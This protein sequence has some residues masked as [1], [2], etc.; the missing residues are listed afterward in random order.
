MECAGKCILKGLFRGVQE[1]EKRQS[2][3]YVRRQ[4]SQKTILNLS[5]LLVYLYT[6]FCAYAKLISIG[7]VV[8]YAASM[9]QMMDCANKMAVA[10]GH[11]KSAAMY[12]ADYRKFLTLQDR[13]Y[14][15]TII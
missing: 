5:T 7:Q 12:A 4:M 6:S 9:T 11:L 3:F 10:L 14:K 13:K 1:S 2:D 8:T 15:G